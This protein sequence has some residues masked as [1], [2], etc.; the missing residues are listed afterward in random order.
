MGKV[1]TGILEPDKK[2]R[3]F[4]ANGVPERRIHGRF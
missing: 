2:K 1:W 3:H 4:S